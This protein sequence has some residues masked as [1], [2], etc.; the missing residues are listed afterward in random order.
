M[1]LS[2]QHQKQ[3]RKNIVLFLICAGLIGLIYAITLMR[4]GFSFS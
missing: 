1:P 3:K 4:M 2:D